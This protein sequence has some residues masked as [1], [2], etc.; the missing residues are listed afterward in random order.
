MLVPVLLLLLLLLCQSRQINRFLLS[1]FGEKNK[2]YKITGYHDYNSP[3]TGYHDY[4]PGTGYHDYRP[5][6]SGN[7]VYLRAVSLHY[8]SLDVLRVTF[9]LH[10]LLTGARVPD[11]EYVLC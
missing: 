8:Y 1:G 5:G 4:S 7:E 10:S 6:A 3:G 11:A 2:E 9:Q